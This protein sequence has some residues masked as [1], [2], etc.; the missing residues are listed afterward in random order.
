MTPVYLER[1]DRGANMAR[2]YAVSVVPT[3]FGSWAVVREWDRI[4]TAGT[5]REDWF[6]AREAAIA[7]AE[8]LIA[9]KRRRGYS[10]HPPGSCPDA[11]PLSTTRRNVHMHTL[12][13][14]DM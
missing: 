1:H 8:A 10:G 4:G 13:Q 14:V 5:V 3:L 12:L 9:R 2:F 11:D 6:P 7:G